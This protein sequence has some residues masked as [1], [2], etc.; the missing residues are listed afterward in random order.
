MAL[1]KCPDCG[2]DVST[3]AKACPNCGAPPSVDVQLDD[4]P[5][6]PVDDG[7]KELPKQKA[8]APNWRKINGALAFVVVVY[9]LL[10]FFTPSPPD[11]ADSSNYEKNYASATTSSGLSN[12]DL[13]WHA[14]NTYGWDCNSVVSKGS[15]ISTYYVITCGNG[16]RLR[17]YPR[18]GQHPKIT[19][20]GGSYK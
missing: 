13:A 18:A 14:Q 17:V 20:A 15:M 9:T 12:A 3:K 5:T 16:T 8:V 6:K 4:L 1:I 19:N 2:H 10:F 7:V 11:R